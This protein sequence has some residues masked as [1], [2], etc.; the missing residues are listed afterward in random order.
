MNSPLIVKDLRHLG[1]HK[2]EHFTLERKE[3][4]GAYVKFKGKKSIQ[5]AD[6]DDYGDFITGHNGLTK[7]QKKQLSSLGYTE[8]EEY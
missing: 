3:K 4:K 8:H 7:S 2:S 1:C 6:I 5:K